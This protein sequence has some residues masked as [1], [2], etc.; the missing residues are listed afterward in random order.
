MSD[1]N[2]SITSTWSNNCS[3]NLKQD[4]AEE[5]LLSSLS[6]SDHQMNTSKVNNEQQLDQINN[7]INNIEENNEKQ[8]DENDNKIAPK[9][10]LTLLIPK[11][12]FRIV[13]D[14]TKIP[15]PDVNRNCTQT[16]FP[17]E[18]GD[19]ITS[20]KQNHTV[21]SSD[22]PV[23][24]NGKSKQKQNRPIMGKN[25]LLKKA[26]IDRSDSLIVQ[27]IVLDKYNP[28]LNHYVTKMYHRRLSRTRLDSSGDED[29]F[30]EGVCIKL[31]FHL[32]HILVH[33]NFK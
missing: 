26:N 22:N 25:A 17:L 27:D 10:P 24:N 29:S 9:Q 7:E 23:M 32:I 19:D 6:F 5:E 15:T 2:T 20:S 16:M 13:N 18:D 14:I 11:T 30:S 3:I 8:L 21:I 33:N 1:L 28:V 4:T 31:I 12:S